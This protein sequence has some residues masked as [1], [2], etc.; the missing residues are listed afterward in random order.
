[1]LFKYL[2]RLL[3]RF[4][5]FARAAWATR[6]RRAIAVAVSVALGAAAIAAG[7]SALHRGPQFSW[8]VSVA[9]GDYQGRA[10][11][12]VR[13]LEREFYNG[14]GLWHMCVP[15]ACNTKNR[16]WGSDSLTYVLYLRWLLT[17]D[18]SVPPIMAT[19]ADT[20]HAWVPADAGSSDTVMWDAIADAR[21]YQVTGKATALAKARQAFAWVDSVMARGFASGAC[22]GIDYQWPYGRGGGLKTLETAT[23]YIKAALLLHEITGSASYLDKAEREYRQVRRYFLVGK[24]PLYTVYVFDDGS[25]CRPLPGRYFAS[26]NGNMIWAGSALAADTGRQGF[27]RQAIATA[28]AVR[29]HLGDG[30][31]VYADLQADNDVVEPLVEG[32]YRLATRDHQR[33]A[34]DWLLAAASAAGGDQNAAGEFGR[35]FDGPPPTVVA[36]AWQVNGGAALMQA[37]AALDPHGRPADPGFW[38][39]AAY[40]ADARGLTG[41]ELRFTVTGRAVAILG[42]VGAVCCLSGHARVFVDGAETFD[43][44]GIWQNMTSPSVRQPDQVLFAWR[45]RSA[46]RHT[47]TIRPGIPDGEEGGS[48]FQ[49]NGYLVVR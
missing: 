48:F 49:M 12:A 20:A 27:A 29:A 23:N 3:A 2:F 42:S 41:S 9:A 32:M 37:A 47:I 31:G 28:S 25:A 43:R 17:R 46:G 39:R 13:V 40:V 30:A 18:P 22:P 35:F 38:Q 24:V 14:T 11:R 10:T 7:S 5:P 16:D 8:R 15:L 4:A 44:T 34:A 36:T 26:V 21:E 1:M 19:L 6:Y 33:M 45:W